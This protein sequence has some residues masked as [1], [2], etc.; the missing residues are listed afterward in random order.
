MLPTSHYPVELAKLSMN[1][2]SFFTHSTETEFDNGSELKSAMS[3]TLTVSGNV[4]RSV[5]KMVLLLVM[6]TYAA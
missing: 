3:G 4:L 2:T 6:W 5:P 1:D